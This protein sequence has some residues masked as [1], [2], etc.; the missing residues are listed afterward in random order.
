MLRRTL[1][2]CVAGTA[3]A[4]SCGLLHAQTWPS[5]PV[6]MIVPFA[7]G[8]TPDLLARILTDRLSARLGQAFVVDN[9]S[10]AAGNI[11]TDVVAKAAPDGY[12]VGVSIAGPLA[13]NPLLFKSM[14]YDPARDVKL[15]TVAATQPSVLVASNKLKASTSKELFELLGHKEGRYSFASMGAGTI[16]Q[17]GMYVLTAN[18]PADMVHVPYAGSG[19]AS[20]ALMSGEV[21]FALLPAASVMP[22]IQAGKM[23]A[24]GVADAKRMSALPNVPTLTE[25]GVRSVTADAWIGVIAPA[26]TPDAI[27]E[28]LRGEI[29]QV[30]AEPAVRE[31]L[32]T[33]TMEAVGGTPVEFRKVLDGELKLWSPVIKQY[34][35]TVQ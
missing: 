10:G 17:M 32:R 24:L 6:R 18:S 8:S 20:L 35:I 28:R 3:L 4:A 9:R 29:L 23:K 15:I 5:K 21:D 13:I 12:T 22:H 30:L 27:T 34:G 19:A 14:P 26:G 11:G 2:Q 1:F 31:K 25:A 33:Q 16:S 7:A